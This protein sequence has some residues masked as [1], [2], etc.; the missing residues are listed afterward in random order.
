MTA[1][2]A[3]TALRRLRPPVTR[4]LPPPRYT[5]ASLV[6]ALDELEH[7][8]SVY[9]RGDHVDHHA[10]RGYVDHRG[11]VRWFPP[12]LAFAVTRLLEENFGRLRRTTTSPPPMEADL[13]RIAAGGRTGSP[14]VDASTGRGTGRALRRSRADDGWPTEQRP[15]GH[16]GQPRRDRRPRHQLHRRSARASPCAW[17][18]YGPYLRGLARGRSAANV[19]ADLAPDELTVAKARELFDPGTPTTAASSAFDPVTGHADRRSRT[20]ATVPTSPRFS[21]PR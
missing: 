1:G 8:P 4:P 3:L 16:G 2:E 12:G 14:G 18:R 9:L 15:K 20:A 5:E 13:D 10:D 17:A 11:Q 7:R 21:S 6:K 19:P